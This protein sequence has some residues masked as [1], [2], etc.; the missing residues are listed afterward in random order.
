MPRM[1]DEFDPTPRVRTSH[2]E[3]VQR[4]TLSRCVA[5]VASSEDDGI[6]GKNGMKTGP[7]MRNLHFCKQ[8][9]PAGFESCSRRRPSRRWGH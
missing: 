3:I 1:L 4:T 5:T 7:T 2:T 6:E 9:E 8:E